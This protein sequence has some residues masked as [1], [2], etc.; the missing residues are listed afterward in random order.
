MPASQGKSVLGALKD[1]ARAV[2]QKHKNDVIEIFG[3]DLP[4]GLE[5]V[6]CLG[7][8]RIEVAPKDA[9]SYPNKPR[10]YA[11]AIV[12]EPEFFTHPDTG[13][14]IKVA[15]RQF[16]N[17]I[18]LC[19]TVV[20]SGKNAGKKVTFEENM[21]KALQE[22]RKVYRQD[23][24]LCGDAGD[25]D[26]PEELAP[27]LQDLNP[28]PYFRFRTRAG[29][30]TKQYPTPRVFT[31]W[32]DG[33][34][35]DYVPPESSANAVQDNGPRGSTAPKPNGKPGPTGTKA[36]P[37][38]TTKSSAPEPEETQEQEEFSYEDADLDQLVSL[39]QPA[40]EGVDGDEVAAAEL[41]RRAGEIGYT[42]EQM[43]EEGVTWQ[44]IADWIAAGPQEEE[45]TE[46]AAA[47]EEPAEEEEWKLK[48]GDEVHYQPIDPKTK[49]KKVDAKKK[50]VFVACKVE[51]V[52]EKK[53]LANLK[54]SD[55]KTKYTGVKWAD[56]QPIE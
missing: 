15:G 3:G 54:S 12:V 39:A 11:M 36:P 34:E 23:R 21:E 48:K 32:L 47:E 14:E 30:V 22:M 10:Y 35:D 27:F 49:K 17:Y 28:P 16:R 19:D 46:E 40:D 9:S 1:R 18:P 25:T 24:D 6:A 41:R 20:K 55:G 2:V 52:D 43:D 26:D 42:D 5:G 44:D 38:R 8:M 4:P 56:L 7:E 45:A 51:S 37:P 31:E 53:E 50:P 29:A 13:V 33:V